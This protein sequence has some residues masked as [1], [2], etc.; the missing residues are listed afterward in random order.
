MVDEKHMTKF[1]HTLFDPEDHTCFARHTGDTMTSPIAEW[2]RQSSAISFSIN[3]LAQGSTRSSLSVS[4]FRSFLLEFDTGTPQEQLD[5]LQRMKC[6]FTSIVHS[7]GKSY[8]MIVTLETTLED[9]ATYN[10]VSRWLHSVMA[11]SDQVAIDPSRMSRYPGAIRPDTEKEQI[12]VYIGSRIPEKTLFGFLDKYPDHRPKIDI[13]GTMTKS[14]YIVDPITAINHCNKLWPL[15][16]SN[17]QNALMS[18]SVYLAGN[19]DISKEDVVDLLAENDRGSNPIHAE[20]VRA[21]DRG[22]AKFGL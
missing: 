19:T 13:G 16:S 18:W 2:Y 22:F 15:E 14:R 10:Y 17:K 8:H 5:Y 20:Y 11:L 7:G 6:P 9:L 4:K 3:A 1:W 21:A 12:L